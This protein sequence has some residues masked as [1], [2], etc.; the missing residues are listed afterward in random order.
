MKKTL[1]ITLLL[2]STA[3]VCNA[4]EQQPLAFNLSVEKSESPYTVYR[5]QSI[6]LS[7]IQNVENNKNLERVSFESVNDKN[8]IR[9]NSVRG[10]NHEEA[11]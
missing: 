4:E 10:D 8:V 5:Q 9:I 6:G 11:K 1:F 3:L 7:I 2:L